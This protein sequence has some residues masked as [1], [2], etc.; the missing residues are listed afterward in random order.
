MDGDTGGGAQRGRRDGPANQDLQRKRLL[1]SAT[2]LRRLCFY[3]CLSVHRVGSASVHA[4]ITLPRRRHPPPSRHPPSRHPPG[5]DWKQAH[6]P[7]PADGYG[8]GQYASYWNAFLFF[9]E[10]S[11][12]CGELFQEHLYKRLLSQFCDLKTCSGTGT[13]TL[14]VYP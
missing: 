7:P 6:S 4:G 11:P 2:N 8:C 14:A 10:I 1:P 3:T 13:G 12:F 5:P 9:D